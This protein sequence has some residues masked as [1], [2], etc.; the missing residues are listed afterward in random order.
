MSTSATPATPPLRRPRPSGP[1]R[2]GPRQHVPSIARSTVS[3]APERVRLVRDS[4]VPIEKSGHARVCPNADCPGSDIVDD[5]MGGG[6]VCRSCGTIL[7]ESNIV[8]EN[9][10]VENPGGVP[11]MTGQYVGS[12]QAAPRAITGMRNRQLFGP[13][14]EASDSRYQSE[15]KARVTLAELKDV[16]INDVLMDQ[17]VQ[18][19]KLAVQHGLLHGRTIE[20]V[21]AVSVYVACRR[22]PGN[23][24]VMLIDIAERLNLNLF[25]LG[26]LYQKM[27]D[28]LKGV[29]GNF[30]AKI[31]PINP[32]SLV[33]RF[34][35]HM[36]FG[37]DKIKIVRDAV[38]IL[39]RMKRDWIVDGR[40]PAGIAAAAIL[41]AARMNNYHRTVREMVLHAKMTEITINKRLWEFN[42]TESAQWHVE[43]FRK[44]ARQEAE[45]TAWEGSGPMSLPP[46]FYMQL[47]SAPKRRRGR[48]RKRPLPENA[49]ETEGEGGVVEEEDNGSPED[50]P[51]PKRVRL[52]AD[53]FKVPALP[54]DPKLRSAGRSLLPA[55][56]STVATPAQSSSDQSSISASTD[57]D[58]APMQT[59]DQVG[60]QASESSPIRPTTDSATLFTID[61]F[62]DGIMITDDQGF[63]PSTQPTS[64][65]LDLQ[66]QESVMQSIEQQ[67]IEQ[68]TNSRA[69]P[70]GGTIRPSLSDAEKKRRL[71]NNLCLYCGWPGHTDRTC[72]A[73]IGASRFKRIMRE[74]ERQTSLTAEERGV[75]PSIRLTPFS[76]QSTLGDG[77]SMIGE[78]S[79]VTFGDDYQSTLADDDFDLGLL[80]TPKTKSPPRSET[81]SSISGE[82]RRVGRPKG[83]KNSKV[84]PATAAELAMETE[85]TDDVTYALTHGASEADR[86]LMLPPSLSTG[87]SSLAIDLTDEIDAHATASALRGLTPSLPLTVVPSGGVPV[88]SIIGNTGTISTSPTLSPTEFDDDPEVSTCLLTDEEANFKEKIWV[89]ENADWLR[90]DHYKRISKELR[91]AQMI[92]E[93][94]D[95]EEE[96]KKKKVRRML[97]TAPYMEQVKA[98]R[99]ERMS[100]TPAGEE[101]DEEQMIHTDAMEAR[102]EMVSN[103]ART[104]FSRRFNQQSIDDIYGN[105][106]EDSRSEHSQSPQIRTAQS[107]ARSRK[108]S[109]STQRSS[110]YETHFP[111]P[112]QDGPLGPGMGRNTHSLAASK[113][114]AKR[115]DGLRKE[116]DALG[117][118]QKI[119]IPRAMRAGA[120]RWGAIRKSKDGSQGSG[121]QGSGSPTPDAGQS[122]EGGQQPTTQGQTQGR[123]GPARPKPQPRPSKQLSRPASSGSSNPALPPEEEVGG[124]EAADTDSP[125]SSSVHSSLAVGR[126][127]GFAGTAEGATVDS[128]ENMSSE[129][130]DDD[131]ELDEDEVDDPEDAFAGKVRRRYTSDDESDEE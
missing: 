53:G 109:Y 21:A 43:E 17:A 40:R 49:A 121:S 29:G 56:D 131:D 127:E 48:P 15:L 63:Q 112:D 89:A 24:T 72:G 45:G 86:L 23:N 62:E 11:G 114:E 58:D 22:N 129:D 36:E 42:N 69:F 117:V 85:L 68:E 26:S 71:D 2:Q 111:A 120:N 126:Q 39:K 14:N 101:L 96:K 98:R 124:I 102:S 81:S 1:R 10:W 76:Q 91:E 104:A 28:K 73:A 115:W 35:D 100:Q 80:S 46:A 52:D 82:K 61:Q 128:D 41:L 59:Q 60:T 97:G 32:E 12:N 92:A 108:S 7:N 88:L 113:R 44:V 79:S 18:I 64:A 37:S 9:T 90:K 8:A 95:P 116:K 33:N 27:V 54:M 75:I 19:Y 30:S 34:A 123:R 65:A 70:I 99:K 87:Q 55:S 130:D 5:E 67:S 74:R 57:L 118:P 107:R 50:E 13:G 38:H 16:G 6:L 105:L 106:A 84:P 51:S 94:R 103:L 119:S 78:T 66:M 125:L 83:T 25:V 4:P 93:G 47:Q 31:D 122:V 3:P 110:D 20:L 77:G